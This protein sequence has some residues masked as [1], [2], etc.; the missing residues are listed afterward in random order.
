MGGA[1]IMLPENQHSPGEGDNKATPSDPKRLPLYPSENMQQDYAPP[2]YDTVPP[3]KPP[4]DTNYEW[5]DD[6]I[7]AVSLSGC[8]ST[9]VLSLVWIAYYLEGQ[10]LSESILD[11]SDDKSVGV[12][13]GLMVASV[14]ALTISAYFFAIKKHP[15]RWRSVG[16]LP[17]TRSWLI[18]SGVIGALFM[19]VNILIVTT[20]QRILDVPVLD[21]SSE[22]TGE[23]FPIGEFLALFV[24]V[25]IIVPIVEEVFFRGIIYKWL[26]QRAGFLIGILVSSVAF[27]T[28][29]VAAPSI[30]SIS[31]L[32]VLCALVYEL[33]GSLWTAVTVHAMNNFLAIVLAYLIWQT[34]SLL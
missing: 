20:G 23:P 13:L 7:A 12:T 28:L 11:G 24:L 31:V 10:G 3:D 6:D 25:V 21:F 29:H 9:V 33:S 19:P 15:Q 27:G 22:S 4:V 26:R 14:V 8:I 34:P 18:A 16:L 2:G 17:S 32:G 5:T 30:A 1:V